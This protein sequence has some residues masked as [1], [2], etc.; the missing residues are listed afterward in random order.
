[1]PVQ[2]SAFV[3]LP[4]IDVDGFKPNGEHVANA[5]GQP[6]RV[7][8]LGKEPLL[9]TYVP[10]NSRFG[11]ILYG[12][13]GTT[14]IIKSTPRLL[15]PEAWTTDPTWG[16]IVLTNLF[17]NL[18]VVIPTNPSMFYRAVQP[19]NGGHMSTQETLN[20]ATPQSEGEPAN[21]AD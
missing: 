21:H 2:T 15:P 13:T 3:T 18:P 19:A 12:R 8:I 20:A 11:I 7:V 14:N 10:T 9:E 1:M 6:G 4:V 5:Y 17:R 16:S